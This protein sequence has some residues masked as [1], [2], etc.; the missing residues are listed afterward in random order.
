MLDDDDMR[1]VQ[2]REQNPGY[3]RGIGFT[4]DPED[5]DTDPEI[6][7]LMAESYARDNAQRREQNQRTA[8]AE[9]VSEATSE[10]DEENQRLREL[11]RKN[12]IEA[13]G[14]V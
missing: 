13:S 12:G 5:M 11:L 4:P 1:D 7:K 6:L 14:D 2:Y 8:L 10:L 9:A 3:E